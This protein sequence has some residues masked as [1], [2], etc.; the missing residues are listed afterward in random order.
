[1]P[2]SEI[3]LPS[4]VTARLKPSFNN[5]PGILAWKTLIG[6]LGD[7]YTW[8]FRIPRFRRYIAF[9]FLGLT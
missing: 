9:Q 1:M 4:L 2:N 7:L 5:W 3:A 6:T 8:E